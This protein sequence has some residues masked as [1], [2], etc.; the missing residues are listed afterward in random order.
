MKIGNVSRNYPTKVK[1][2]K[3]EVNKGKEKVDVEHI[4]ANMKKRWKKRD[5]PSTSN[6]GFTSPKRLSDHTSSN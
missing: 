5:G 3:T 4:K 2:P 6:G 1:A